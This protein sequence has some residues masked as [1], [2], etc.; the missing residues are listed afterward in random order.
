M[1]FARITSLGYDVVQ[2]SAGPAALAML[3]RDGSIE[4]LFTDIVLPEGISGLELARRARAIRPG[5]RVLFTSGYPEDAIDR[6]GAGGR[7]FLL[8]RKPYHRHQLA[9]ALQEA[10]TGRV[11][12][13]SA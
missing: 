11:S 10:L 1:S 3:Q 13:G 7:D 5:L 6:H 12:E 2:A 9:S 4:L 8:L